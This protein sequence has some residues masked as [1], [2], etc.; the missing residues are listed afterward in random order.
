[1]FHFQVMYTKHQ[2]DADVRHKRFLVKFLFNIC[3]SSTYRYEKL[4]K[5]SSNIPESTMSLLTT[6]LLRSLTSSKLS[7]LIYT[8]YRIIIHYKHGL[9]IS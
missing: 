4:Q 2:L 7:I 9:D 6:S 3:P 1:M 5:Q 8:D